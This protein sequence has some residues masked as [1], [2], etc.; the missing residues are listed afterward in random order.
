MKRS[1]INYAID[2]ALAVSESFRL[3]LPDFAYFT[4]AIWRQ[5]PLDEWQE[6]L[7]LQLG[8]DITDFGGGN[9]ADTGLTLLT[10]RNGA[11]H[12]AQYPKPY[13][14]KM[15]QI[16]QEQHTPWHFHNYKMEDIINRGG[17]DLCMQLAWSTEDKQ[18]DHH[19]AIEITVDGRRRSIRPTEILVL[20][21]GQGIC[22]PRRLYHRFWAEKSFVLGW[23]ISMVNDDWQDNHFLEAGERYSIVV[24]NEPIKWLLCNEYQ[25]LA[26]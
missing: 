17:G 6:V 18:L 9:F 23:E 24:E 16:Q 26:I 19:R 20:K 10:L 14:E 22:L 8:W 1:S 12:N 21:P 11:L 13:A 2:K 5:K 15:L 4:A 7:D 25:R 3:C